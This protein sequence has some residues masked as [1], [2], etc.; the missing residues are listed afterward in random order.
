M[1]REILLKTGNRA[2]LMNL[3]DTT[4]PTVRAALRYETDTDLAKRIRHYAIKEMHG[5]VSEL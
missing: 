1:T 3:F 4:Y 2:K 5:V